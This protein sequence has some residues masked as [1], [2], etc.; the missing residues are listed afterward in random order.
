[1]TFRS[2]V[3]IADTSVLL[4]L[5]AST[6]FEAILTALPVQVCVAEQVVRETK[7]LRFD[8]EE[9]E[10]SLTAWIESGLLTIVAVESEEEEE[11]Y[12]DFALE[13]DDGEAVTGAIAKSR[14]WSIAVEDKKAR[15]V[16]QRE[17]GQCEMHRTSDIIFYAADILG[18]S[19][20]V[21]RSALLSVQSLATFLPPNSDSNRKR[22][23]FL[24]DA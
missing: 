13:L 20:D 3:L 22:W 19:D 23:L 9:R 12:V 2:P 11:D 16:F 15:K 6:A 14:L 8:T 4:N 10:I 7:H 17:I 24:T 21:L 5:I 18:W 1:M